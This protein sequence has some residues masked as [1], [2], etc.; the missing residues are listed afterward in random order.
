MF[1]RNWHEADWA[2]D[3]GTFDLILCNPPYIEDNAV[4][5]PDVRDYEPASALFAGRE[6][7]DDYRVIIPQLGKLLNRGGIAILE[8]GHSQAEAV[9]AIAQQAGFRVEIRNDLANRPRALILS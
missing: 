2:D 4:L 3:L 8:I 5:D 1:Q 6:G 7:L 9:S